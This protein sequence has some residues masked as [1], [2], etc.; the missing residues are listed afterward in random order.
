MRV[1]TEKA[2]GALRRVLERRAH[3]ERE[4]ARV[5]RV[6]G[7]ARAVQLVAIEERGDVDEDRARAVERRFVKGDVVALAAD[8]QRKAADATCPPRRRDT[9][10]APPSRPTRDAPAP[11]A[12]RRAR[13]R[14]RRSSQTAAPPNR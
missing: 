3:Q 2:D 11:A 4:A 10:A 12:A 7:A 8:G 1:D 6:V 5:V 13:R 9:A 14:G